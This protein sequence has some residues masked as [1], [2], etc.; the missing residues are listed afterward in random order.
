[1]KISKIGS[2]NT[3]SKCLRKLSEWE[4]VK[5]TPSKSQFIA[6]KI[7]M[8]R[9]D[10]SPDTTPDTTPDT[11]CDT[12]PVHHVIQHLIHHVVQHLIQHLYISCDLS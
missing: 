8:Y 5:Y 10:T 1:M 4:H 11:S 12:T 6:S 7:H 3:Y 2:A 9:F